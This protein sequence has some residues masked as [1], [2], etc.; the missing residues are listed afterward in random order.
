MTVAQVLVDLS[1]LGS[2][3]QGPMSGVA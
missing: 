2:A 1:S 3:Q